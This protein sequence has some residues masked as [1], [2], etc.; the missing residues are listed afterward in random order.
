MATSSG[1]SAVVT[2][3]DDDDDGGGDVMVLIAWLSLQLGYEQF[4]AHNNRIPGSNIINIH[5][6]SSLFTIHTVVRHKQN[7]SIGLQQAKQTRHDTKM[8]NT[9]YDSYY[10]NTILFIYISAFDTSK[11]SLRGL[12]VLSVRKNTHALS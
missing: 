4:Y 12:R 11:M 3:S 6:F 9:F 7:T 10:N 5:Q 1:R 2:A 8:K